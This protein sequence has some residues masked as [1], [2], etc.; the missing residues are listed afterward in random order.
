MANRRPDDVRR[1][2][3]ARPTDSPRATEPAPLA[4]P[5]RR[6][7]RNRKP[8]TAAPV[9]PEARRAMVAE[10]AYLRAERRGFEPGHEEEDWL[11]AETEVDALLR[12]GQGGSPQ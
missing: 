4:D 11:E 5:L 6:A 3:P 8:G 9:T 7:S 1:S 2:D 12:A 10:N